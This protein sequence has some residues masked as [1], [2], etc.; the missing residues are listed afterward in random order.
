MTI[1]P[2]AAFQR[3]PIL[4]KDVFQVITLFLSSSKLLD[5]AEAGLPEVEYLDDAFW[6]RRY[7]EYLGNKQ[8]SSINK[9][10]FKEKYRQTFGELKYKNI[11][12]DQNMPK[13]PGTDCK[14]SLED[15]IDFKDYI[16]E[17][18][19]ADFV[20]WFNKMA[21]GV[22]SVTNKINFIEKLNKCRDQVRNDDIYKL[23]DI[24]SSAAET[25][26]TEIMDWIKNESGRYEETATIH[27]MIASRFISY[28]FYCGAERGHIEVLDWIKDK[29]GRYEKITI[30]DMKTAFFNGAEGGHI[31]VLDWIK[32]KSKRYEEIDISVI[33]DALRVSSR[34]ENMEVLDWIEKK[35]E[36]FEELGFPYKLI[37]LQ[38]R[39]KAG[40]F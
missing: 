28:A 39:Y 32:D 35:S 26:R 12:R 9:G 29:S 23:V 37:P 11:L 24:F 33:E 2:I 7:I 22:E 18:D 6:E 21:R 38:M 14:A 19:Y 17:L 13:L 20:L 34:N 27:I 8:A 30:A 3:K 16:S 25:N 15:L 40:I 10:E 5:L 36:R 4:N 1:T 31:E